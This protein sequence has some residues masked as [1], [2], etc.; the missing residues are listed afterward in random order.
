MEQYF[1]THMEN[2][3]L[4]LIYSSEII[5]EFK[6]TQQIDTKALIPTFQPADA[7]NFNLRYLGVVNFL[8]EF[9]KD[10]TKMAVP[11]AKDIVSSFQKSEV[12]IKNKSRLIYEKEIS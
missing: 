7:R 3:E 10:K 5:E 2:I 1:H 9:K 11:Q 6:T 8:F 12:L 4:N